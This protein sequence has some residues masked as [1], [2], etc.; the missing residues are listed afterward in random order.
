MNSEIVRPK[1]ISYEFVIIVTFI[2]EACFNLLAGAMGMIL[3]F[4]LLF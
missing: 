2:R 3:I 1:K 4:F